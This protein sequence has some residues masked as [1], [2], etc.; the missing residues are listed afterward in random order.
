MRLSTTPGHCRGCLVAFQERYNVISS[1]WALRPA[2][3]ADPL[4]PLDVYAD[5]A[6]CI[7]SSW[8]NWAKAAQQ[9]LDQMMAAVAETRAA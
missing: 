4:T 5:G 1:H 8:R 3:G 9:K 7:I 6:E 2:S